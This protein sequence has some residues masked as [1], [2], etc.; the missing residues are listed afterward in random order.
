MP[1]PK[2]LQPQDLVD[3]NVN[4]DFIQLDDGGLTLRGLS[5]G[6]P[7]RLRVVFGPEG[8]TPV[9]RVISETLRNIMKQSLKDGSFYELQQSMRGW[10]MWLNWSD[11]P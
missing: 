7:L 6:S 11:G 9:A 3:L 8:D 10:D 4:I 2:N 5:N 1:L